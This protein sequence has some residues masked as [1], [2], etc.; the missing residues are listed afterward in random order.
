[1]SEDK[2]VLVSLTPVYCIVL[3]DPEFP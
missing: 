2:G 3:S 1:M